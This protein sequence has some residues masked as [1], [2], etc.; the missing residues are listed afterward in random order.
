MQM[1]EIENIIINA[2]VEAAKC[3]H[4]NEPMR[5]G[6]YRKYSH[7]LDDELD[8]IDADQCQRDI[9]HRKLAQAL[10]L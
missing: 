2:N 1:N 4:R 8:Y 6:L 7:N 9:A 5:W 3:R 10:G